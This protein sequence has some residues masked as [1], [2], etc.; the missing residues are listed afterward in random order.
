M[1]QALAL[2]LGQR[3][4]KITGLLFV[5]KPRGFMRT[6]AER[7]AG[8]VAATAKR[9][10]GAPGKAVR[11]AIHIEKFDFPFDT[12]GTII[13]DRDFCWWHWISS[14]IVR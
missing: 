2:R 12:Q 11:L 5:L 8:G 9:D 10:C 3:G 1:L 13:A 7:L 6:V 14:A 4:R